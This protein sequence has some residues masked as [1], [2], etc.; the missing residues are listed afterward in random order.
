MGG[1]TAGVSSYIAYMLGVVTNKRAKIGEIIY[2][3]NNVDYIHLLNMGYSAQA[4]P[5]FIEQAIDDAVNK[6]K[7]IKL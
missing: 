1:S 4:Q 5:K 3:S 7:G 2:I 6:A